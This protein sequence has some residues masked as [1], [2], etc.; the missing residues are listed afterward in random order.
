MPNAIKDRNNSEASIKY[1]TIIYFK[2]SIEISNLRESRPR[3]PIPPR[4][5]LPLFACWQVSKEQADEMVQYEGK[6]GYGSWE[7]SVSL[8]L[9]EQQKFIIQAMTGSAKKRQEAILA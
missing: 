9:G 2:V 3:T 7:L 4:S 6:Y 8:L 5:G 1:A